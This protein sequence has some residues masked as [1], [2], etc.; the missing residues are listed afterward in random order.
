M[1]SYTLGIHVLQTETCGTPDKL[2]AFDW[3]WGRSGNATLFPTNPD[4]PSAFELAWKLRCQFAGVTVRF[5]LHF[6][7]SL[8]LSSFKCVLSENQPIRGLN[9]PGTC[10]DP[11]DSD[12][13]RGFDPYKENINW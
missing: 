12:R 6:R 5:Q 7:Y 3:S 10:Q 9:G 8:A 4:E 13:V 11:S 2:I 1:D